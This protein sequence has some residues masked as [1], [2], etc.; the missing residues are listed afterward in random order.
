MAG[1]I[2]LVEEYEN[3]DMIV[4]VK[5]CLDQ[6]EAAVEASETARD[7]SIASAAEAHEAS[8]NANSASAQAQ[9]AASTVATYGARLQ[10][11]EDESSGNRSSI[12]NIDGEIND[13]YNDLTNVLRKVGDPGQIV[14]NGLELRGTNRTPDTVVGQLDD[15]IVNAKRLIEEI[16]AKLNAYA[17]MVRTTGNQTIDGEKTFNDTTTFKQP[18]VGLFKHL[19]NGPSSR[20]KKLYTRTDTGLVQILMFVGGSTIGFATVGDNIQ[21][22]V[23]SS[24]GRPY[25]QPIFKVCTD[26]NGEV[27][28]HMKGQYSA[29]THVY[30]LANFRYGS[31]YAIDRGVRIDGVDE[32]E[33]VLGETYVVIRDSIDF[34]VIR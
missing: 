25:P 5:K 20:W 31:D 30:M 14:Y 6:T 26:V 27:S 21:T 28:V 9:T 10:A 11:V 34:G 32:D 2:S 15:R 18:A 33:P 23:L 7:V 16:D 12:Q 4:Q 13:I 8:T 17:Q 1:R 22:H 3:K 29:A 19:I 24:S